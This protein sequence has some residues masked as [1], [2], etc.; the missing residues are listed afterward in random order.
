MKQFP[1]LFVNMISQSSDLI[2]DALDSN[3]FGIW[4]EPDI[5]W[6]IRSE[7]ELNSVLVYFMHDIFELSP[8][9]SCIQ[10]HYYSNHQQKLQNTTRFSIFIHSFFPQIHSLFIN[11]NL[12]TCL[13]QQLLVINKQ[14]IWLV[15]QQFAARARY[16]NG[17]ISGKPEPDIQCIPRPHLFFI[18]SEERELLAVT[19]Q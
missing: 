13:P 15:I 7:S 4:P 16:K 3:F 19:S 2:R 10:Q 12:P 8:F 6:D 18:H 5:R 11:C 9:V 14:I 1:F 17:R